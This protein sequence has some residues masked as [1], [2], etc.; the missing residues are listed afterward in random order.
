LEGPAD[1]RGVSYPR[2]FR[3]VGGSRPAASPCRATVSHDLLQLAVL[4]LALTR[5][6][7]LRWHQATVLPAPI[8]AF[9]LRQGEEGTAIGEIC[10]KAGISEARITAVT[11]LH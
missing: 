2:D 7:H 1:E 5:S 11:A 8:V 9:G 4:F 3:A 10:R 6:L